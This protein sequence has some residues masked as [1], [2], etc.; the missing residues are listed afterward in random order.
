MTFL[1]FAGE[2]LD[3]LLASLGDGVKNLVADSDGAPSI[4]RARHRELLRK[5]ASALK[6][7]RTSS[8]PV[9]VQVMQAPCLH[10]E[11]FLGASMIT[12]AWSLSPDYTGLATRV[13]ACTM[14]RDLLRKCASA[15]VI[16]LPFFHLLLGLSQA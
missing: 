7:F 14:C 3:D 4:T 12:C 16:S 6:R 9:D 15:F 10:R 2:G 8:F 5:C 13:I 11:P 1:C